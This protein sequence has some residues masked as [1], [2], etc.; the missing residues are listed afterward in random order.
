MSR[1]LMAM[2]VSSTLVFG[3]ISTSAWSA[4]DTV[5]ATQAV[6]AADSPKNFS[7]LPPGGAAGIKEAQGFD[8]N[9]PWLGLGIVAGI[10][11]I[12]WILLDDDDDDEEEAPSTGTN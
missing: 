12:A 11:I 3:S 2:L 6:L 1:K 7:P 5:G 9:S 10:V 8:E 4:T